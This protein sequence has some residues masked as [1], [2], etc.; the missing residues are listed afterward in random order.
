MLWQGE[1]IQSVTRFHELPIPLVTLKTLTANLPHMAAVP[2]SPED[3]PPL[4]DRGIGHG[5]G[6]RAPGPPFRGE[7]A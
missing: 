7:G 5:K 3:L 4:R 2:R 1:P 6:G